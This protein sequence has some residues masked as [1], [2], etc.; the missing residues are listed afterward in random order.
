M[1]TVESAHGSVNAA[2]PTTAPAGR[3]LRSIGAVL[4]GLVATFVITT[5]TDVALHATGF[6]PPMDVRMA[7]ALFIVALA[8]RI[9]FNI[10]GSYVAARL[11]PSRPMLHALALGALGVIIATVGAVAMWKLGPPWYSLANIAV[12][13]PCAWIGGKMRERAKPVGN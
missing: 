10:T 5:A 2:T 6:F 4:G 1:N 3:T 12:A 8:Y 7:D 11:A 9:P 13:I